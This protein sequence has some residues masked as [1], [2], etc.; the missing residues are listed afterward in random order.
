MKALLDKLKSSHAWQQTVASSES[1]PPAPASAESRS[2]P[3]VRP[4]VASL[5]AQLAGTSSGHSPL[6]S[7]LAEPSNPS[8]PSDV[9]IGHSLHAFSF[10]QTLAHL[11]QLSD[12][13]GFVESIRRVRLQP[14]S[15]SGSHLL[16]LAIRFR[17]NK[18]PS[19]PNCGTSGSPFNTNIRRGSM[20][21]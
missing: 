19:N 16:N 17:K 8:A 5:L 11:A 2:D 3:D 10:Q 15:Q 14:V 9:S 12:K 21:P 1:D 20:L 13:P 18:A 7:A 4:S 6:P